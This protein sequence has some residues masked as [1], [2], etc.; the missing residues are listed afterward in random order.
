MSTRNIQLVKWT[1][2]AFAFIVG[3]FW[4]KRRRVDRV[5]PGGVNKLRGEIDDNRQDCQNN[6]KAQKGHMN[7]YD[8]GIHIDESYTLNS[9][10]SNS[11]ESQHCSPRRVSQS[12]D[13][14]TRRSGSQQIAIQ[15]GKSLEDKEIC[16]YESP[17]EI[18]TCQAVVLGSNPKSTNFDMSESMR[19]IMARK[20]VK[21]HGASRDNAD[22]KIV[23][24][25]DNVTEEEETTSAA[26]PNATLIQAENNKLSS[27]SNDCLNVPDNRS[28][29]RD[30]TNIGEPKVTQGQVICERD[31]A[32]HSP[33]SGVLEGSV[34][35][36][37][38]SEGSTDSGKGLF[39]S[40]KFYP[41]DF[42]CKITLR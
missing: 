1:L 14:P 4:Y 15:S 40:S 19:E 36:E 9:S 12:L 32:N 22:N 39:F 5:D 30:E 28:E 35:D 7:L 41:R 3:F 21:I 31:S 16:W 23:Q 38:R 26:V 13:I 6:S 2:P 18:K 8:S 34:T 20:S 11:E 37:V 33:V 29:S 10:S 42:H 27:L 24:I 25:F 17:D